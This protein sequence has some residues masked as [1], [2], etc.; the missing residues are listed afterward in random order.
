MEEW[1]ICTNCVSVVKVNYISRCSKK[2]E[3]IFISSVL[4]SSFYLI[5]LVL[6][7]C[8]F[9][10]ILYIITEIRNE[11]K[12]NIISYYNFHCRFPQKLCLKKHRQHCRRK[13]NKKMIYA[14][15]LRLNFNKVFILGPDR[16]EST[17]YHW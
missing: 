7:M 13:I 15:L 11:L 16:L 17:N 8:V 10:F 2:V 6:V 5:F 4:I 9:L 12:R 1:Y 14:M 3:A